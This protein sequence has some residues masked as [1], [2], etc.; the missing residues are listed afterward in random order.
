MY[1]GIY[2]FGIYKIMY[3]VNCDFVCLRERYVMLVILEMFDFV[4]IVKVKIFS[5]EFVLLLELN[6]KRL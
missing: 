4:I 5:V 1:F 2:K 3:V 6:F